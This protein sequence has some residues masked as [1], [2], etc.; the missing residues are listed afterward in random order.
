MSLILSQ[1]TV[2]GPVHIMV[3]DVEI[4]VDVASI[5]RHQVKLSYTAPDDVVILRDKLYWEDRD[6]VN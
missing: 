2:S 1:S 5:G 4:L 3:G 6:N